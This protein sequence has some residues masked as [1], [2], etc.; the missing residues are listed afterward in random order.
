MTCSYI[1]WQ[2]AIL[3]AALMKAKSDASAAIFL[4]FRD[5]RGQREVLIATAEMTLAGSNNEMFDAI[6]VLYGSLQS[7]RVDCR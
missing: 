6:M 1:D 2:M 3:L 7:T 4:T 5:A